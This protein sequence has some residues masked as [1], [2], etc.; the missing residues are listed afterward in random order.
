[1]QSGGVDLVVLRL[2]ATDLVNRLLSAKPRVL[3]GRNY[4]MR[5]VGPLAVTPRGLAFELL[6]VNAPVAQM[7]AT[8]LFR[9]ASTHAQLALRLMKHV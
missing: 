8:E 2:V 9:A 4:S 1:M 6:S 5:V 3:T 7:I